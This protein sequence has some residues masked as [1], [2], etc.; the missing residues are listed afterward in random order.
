M[1]SA[2]HAHLS[3]DL[4][5]LSSS[6]P[7]STFAINSRLSFDSVT[8]AHCT[9]H[10]IEGRYLAVSQITV[11]IHDGVPFDLEWCEAESDR[12][13]SGTISHGHAHVGDRRSPLWVRC[14]ASPSFLAFALEE[15]FMAEVWQKGFDGTG[16][17]AIRPSI[18]VDDPVIRR[19]GTLGLHE[20]RKGGPGG[21]LYMEGLAAMLSVHLLRTYGISRRSPIR[22]KGGLAPLQM[23]RVIDYIDAH[24]AEELGIIELAAIAGLSPHHFGEAF[25]TSVGTSPH[26]FVIERRVRHASHLLHDKDRSIAEVA[27]AAG[28]SSQSHFTTNL[29]RVTGM[30]PG[31][32]RRSL[33]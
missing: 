25:K 14:R 3:H 13:G 19:I 22:H 12:V 10:P 33:R 8:L 27:R 15:S 4:I 16:E 20:L 5:D 6:E 2:E 24:L 26:R 1:N 32:F 29:R 31:R 23:R 11:A 28:F 7:T 30:T 17:F 18:G 21:R 9:S